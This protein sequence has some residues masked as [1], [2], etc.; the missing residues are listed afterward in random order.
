VLSPIPAAD[1]WARSFS[2]GRTF[3]SAVDGAG[4]AH[5]KIR[6]QKELHLSVRHREYK[7]MVN[8]DNTDS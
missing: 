7:E 1:I 8:E 5:D 4:P 6:Q 3:L 2:E